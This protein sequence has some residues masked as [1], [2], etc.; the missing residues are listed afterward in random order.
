MHINLESIILQINYI[1]T[2]KN[3]M[4]QKPSFLEI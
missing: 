2:P 4:E 3:N 1:Y